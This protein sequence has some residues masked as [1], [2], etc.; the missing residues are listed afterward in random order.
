MIQN[1]DFINNIGIT[2]FIDLV[3][4]IIELLA[5]IKFS[6]NGKYDNK[7]FLRCLIDFFNIGVS[8]RKY[9]G[10]KSFPIDGKYLNAIHNK[11]TKNGVYEQ[12]NKLIL[13]K[14]LQNGKETK[15]KYQM[16]DSTYIAN[17]GGSVN[18]NN[19]LLSNKT[20]L[21]NKKNK[22]LNIHLPKNKKKKIET[23]IDFNRY[24]GRKKYIK[25]SSITN[26]YGAPLAITMISSKQSD[27]I[28]I[29]ET[30]NK[31]PINLNTLRN[32]KN[33]RYKQHFIGDA[34][35]DSNKN[36]TYLKKL[37]YT[38][39]IAYNRKNTK[40]QNIINKNKLKG[41]QLE[42]YKKRFIIESFFSWIK[43][44]PVINQN[45]Q[46]TIESYYG[47]LLLVCSFRLFNKT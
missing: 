5:P 22:K 23:F 14:Y 39:I 29:Q 19:H 10:T 34:L 3:N 25:I 45:Y 37:G 36:K 11:F 20:K 12:I 16:I 24:N 27:T 6:P 33:N 9:N 38:P 42:I 18:N 13:T 17:K 1:N 40:N 21:K 26:S 7:Y 44:Y 43:N 31:I 41:K 35:Y 32:S 15:L 8:W 46:K 2:K 4:P 28:S 30:I 47:L